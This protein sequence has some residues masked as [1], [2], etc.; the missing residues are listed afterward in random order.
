[1][2]LTAGGYL[3]FYMPG[4]RSSL[5]LEFSQPKSLRSLLM[6]VGIPLKEVQL[7]VLNGKIVD[8]DEVVVENRDKVRV[9]SPIDGG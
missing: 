4:K 7:V 8:L 2:K 1:M 9:Y 5:E 3:V 6:E